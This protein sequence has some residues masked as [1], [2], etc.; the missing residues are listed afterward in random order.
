MEATN[1]PIFPKEIIVSILE[2]VRVPMGLSKEYN[3]KLDFYAL[4]SQWSDFTYY[5]MHVL[6]NMS[7]IS[8][9]PQK[10]N[11]RR[12]VR[13]NKFLHLN[14]KIRFVSEDSDGDNV[15]R[16][17]KVKFVYRVYRDGELGFL[18]KQVK[19]MYAK[20]ATTCLFE[21][22]FY[23]NGLNCLLDPAETVPY[24]LKNAKGL[25]CCDFSDH[26]DKNT[27]FLDAL[28]E[29]EIGNNV[30]PLWEPYFDKRFN[31]DSDHK[32]KRVQ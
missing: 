12:N 31:V 25:S 18:Y 20:V 19:P 24:E 8:K 17:C 13:I 14:F 4:T 21:N 29:S 27:S 28:L 23:I 30:D 11:G 26:D 6:A 5:G 10:I 32:F 3:F 22:M 16:Y 1:Q 7:M 2:Q 9:G 15:Y